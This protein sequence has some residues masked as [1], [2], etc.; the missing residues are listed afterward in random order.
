M[1]SLG[2]EIIHG[3]IRL[4]GALWVKKHRLCHQNVTSTVSLTQ[5]IVK[6]V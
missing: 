1:L 3:H 5:L 6:V 4:F 2:E